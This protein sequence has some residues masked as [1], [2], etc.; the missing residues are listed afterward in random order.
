[1]LVE[2]RS[3]LDCPK[4]DRVGGTATLQRRRIIMA[5]DRALP[6]FVAY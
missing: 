4:L 3:V 6:S 1:M 2:L 5:S